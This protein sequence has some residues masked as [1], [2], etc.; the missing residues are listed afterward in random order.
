MTRINFK[1]Y[2]HNELRMIVSERLRIAKVIDLIE[3]DALRLAS[4]RIANVS[5][6]ARRMLDICRFVRLSLRL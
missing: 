4:M 5:G 1:P 3:E 2:Q 6:D